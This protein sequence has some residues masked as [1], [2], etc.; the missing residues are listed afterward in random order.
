MARIRHNVKLTDYCVEMLKD[1]VRLE[2]DIAKQQMRIAYNDGKE[3]INW[4]H[5]LENLVESQNAVAHSIAQVMIYLSL[6]KN[7]YNISDIIK[8]DKDFAKELL[9]IKGTNDD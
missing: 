8:D 1:Y 3:D 5:N 2:V 7:V 4:E 6:Q 9:K